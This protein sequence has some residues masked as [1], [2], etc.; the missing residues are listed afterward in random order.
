MAQP[1]PSEFTEEIP[2]D[3]AD[4]ALPMPLLN[5]LQEERAVEP[6]MDPSTPAGHMLLTVDEAMYKFS[7]HA[8]MVLS[9][10]EK[11]WE[12]QLQRLAP[13]DR[14]LQS[15]AEAMKAFQP[16][17]PYSGKV[18]VMTPAGYP[19]TVTVQTG[20]QEEFMARMGAM[21]S[22][23]QDNNFQPGAPF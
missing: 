5:Q 15:L 20:S 21:L 18:N 3:I 12:A 8:A 7:N 4:P 14:A 6:E 2:D 11:S 10:I 16:G 22:F 1:A 19:L 17:M 9:T 13:N 23:F